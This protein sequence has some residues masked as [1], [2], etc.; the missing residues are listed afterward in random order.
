VKP[1]AILDTSALIALYTVGRLS[2][3]NLLFDEVRLPR[4][5]REE[6]VR[7]PK[8]PAETDAREKLLLQLPQVM[9]WLVECDDYTTEAVELWKDKHKKIHAGEAEVLAQNQILGSVHTLVLDETI[10]RGL[11]KQ[12]NLKVEGTAK[13][14]AKFALQGLCDYQQDVHQLRQRIGFRLSDTWANKAMQEAAEELGVPAL[15]FN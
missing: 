6:F 10:A 12:K 13:L 11:A 8:E 15:P 5:V 3:L 9:P 7:R 1:A 4:K 14:L 2:L